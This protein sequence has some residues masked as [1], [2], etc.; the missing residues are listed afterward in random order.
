MIYDRIHVQAEFLPR[1]Q[2]STFSLGAAMT[3]EVVGLHGITSGHQ[4]IYDVEV[5]TAVVTMTM[6]DEHIP[7]SGLFRRP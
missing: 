5:P 7:V 2:E 4:L 3:S 1:H 6:H